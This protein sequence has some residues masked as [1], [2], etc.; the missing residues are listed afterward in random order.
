MADRAIEDIV[1]R[2]KQP[3]V[4]GGTFLWVR[5]LLFGLAKAPPADSNVR[6]AHKAFVEEFGRA[7]LHA[8]L[9]SVDPES[10]RRLNANDFVRVSRAL[11]VVELTGKA[12]SEFQADHGFK[13]PRYHFRLIGV[14]LTAEELTAR[15][16]TRV[17]SML[18]LGWEAEVRQL[19]AQGYGDTRPMASVGYRQV[20]ENVRAEVPMD[21]DALLEAVVRVTRVF[22]RRQRTWLRDE[23]VQWLAPGTDL[24][25]SLV[26]SEP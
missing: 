20:A 21:R 9:Q 23:P 6:T 4:C 14:R 12:L 24:D 7:A 18:E 17:R 22:A 19:L 1:A 3:I 13:T 8:K 25:E 26:N 11:E 15:I 5:A 16:A 2:G 10:Y